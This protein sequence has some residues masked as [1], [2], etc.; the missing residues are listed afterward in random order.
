MNSTLEA[1][2]YKRV[3]IEPTYPKVCKDFIGRYFGMG[4][5]QNCIFYSNL[6]LCSKQVKTYPA[7][8]DKQYLDMICSLNCYYHN[9]GLTLLLKSDTIKELK[10]EIIYTILGI[11]EKELEYSG[12]YDSIRGI[13]Q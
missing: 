9:K 10:D 3:K 8:T 7:I 4:E 13:L 11:S 5:C 12:L 1:E 6:T 2:L